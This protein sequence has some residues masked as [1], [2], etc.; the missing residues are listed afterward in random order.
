MKVV[1]A[2]PTSC[3]QGESPLLAISITKTTSAPAVGVGVSTDTVTARSLLRQAC[4]SPEAL[5]ALGL[6][7]SDVLAEALADADGDAEADAD[8]AVLV[9]DAEV[10]GTAAGC[11]SPPEGHS[12]ARMATTPS[13]AAISTIRLRQYTDSGS[14]PTGFLIVS[15]LE[16]VN[17][18]SPHNADRTDPLRSGV[19]TALRPTTAA[20]GT[21]GVC[22]PPTADRGHT[23]DVVRCQSA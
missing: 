13:T 14:G 18:S 22:G 7:S 3:R 9:G 6:G 5:V 12:H 4:G 21:I 11:D 1:A 10:L 19:M 23:G 16:T 15:T 17:P 20:H 8:A 2:A